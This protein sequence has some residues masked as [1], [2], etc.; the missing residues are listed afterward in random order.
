[1][2]A[3]RPFLVPLIVACA[4]FM[5]NLDATVIATALPAIADSF[6]ENPVH[7]NLAISCYLLSLAVFVPVSGWVA[8]RVGARTV[9]RLAIL[10]F[11]LISVQRGS[12][13][14]PVDRTRLYRITEAIGRWSMVDIFV[15]TILVALVRLGNL[16]TVEAQTGAVFFGAVVVLTMLAAESFD[17]RLIWDRSEARRA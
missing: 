3:S 8:D 1:M 14:R 11:L 13:W 6:G 4:L 17:P 2:P 15:V 9:F 12:R 10:V 7:L 5:E 16:A